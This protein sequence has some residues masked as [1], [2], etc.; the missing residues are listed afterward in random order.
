MSS[1]IQSHIKVIGIL[2]LVMGGLGLLAAI[3]LLLLFGG[4]AGV[5][6]ANSQSHDD[7]LAIPVLGGIG[8]ILFVIIAVLSLPGMVCGIGLLLYKPW[9][10]ILAIVL[11]V[12]H[13]LNFP[14][15]TAMG[16]YSLWALLSP[17]GEALFRRPV[18][19][20]PIQATGPRW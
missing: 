11:S 12:L 5:V 13:L 10:R 16:A 2:H 19:Y 1:H 17:E 8:F 3:A 20:A 9:A 15:G 6:G 7:L 18:V 4:L 14:F